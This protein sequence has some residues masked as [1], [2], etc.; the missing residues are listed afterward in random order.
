MKIDGPV[1]T[2]SHEAERILRTL[3]VLQL[4]KAL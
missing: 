4:I 1:S 2:M 3:P